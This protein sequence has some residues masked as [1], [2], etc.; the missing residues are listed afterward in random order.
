[1]QARGDLAQH[2]LTAAEQ[3]EVAERV[4]VV[5]PDLRIAE[6]KDAVDEVLPFLVVGQPQRG[7]TFAIQYFGN[8]GKRCAEWRGVVESVSHPEREP[9]PV[10]RVTL[11]CG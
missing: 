9:P 4:F 8:F 7:R 5:D 3:G 11:N 6:L 1:M 10:L 2:F